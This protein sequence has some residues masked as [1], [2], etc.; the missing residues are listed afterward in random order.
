MAD[1]IDR[2]VIRK[3]KAVMDQVRRSE[4]PK[5]KKLVGDVKSIIKDLERH[6]CD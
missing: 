1:G 5:T 4:D 6:R 2:R 3:L